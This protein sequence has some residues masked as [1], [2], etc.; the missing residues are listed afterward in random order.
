MFVI[1]LD[2]R[3]QIANHAAQR[4][5]KLPPLDCGSQSSCGLSSPIDIVIR[6]QESAH[7]HSSMLDC[8]AQR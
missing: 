8:I 2:P 5:I 7:K 6:C 4:V 3:A 1:S